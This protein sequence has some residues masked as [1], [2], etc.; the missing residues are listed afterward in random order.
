MLSDRV[1]NL[2]PSPTLALSAKAKELAAEGKP[3]I[4]FTAG[5]PDFSTP[6]SVKAA[7]IEAIKANHT[8]YTAAGGMPALREAV[9]NLLNSRYPVSYSPN[10]VIINCGAKHTL[11]NLFQALC[12][13][14][15]EVIIIS[16]YWV[17]YPAMVALAGGKPVIV[18]AEAQGG[19]IP[20][21][22]KI[23]AA[24]GPRTRAVIL[25]SPSNPTGAVMDANTLQRI[26]EIAA[27]KNVLVISDEIY[28]ELVYPPLKH[29]SVLEVASKLTEKLV[30]IGGV[31]K[32]YSMTGWRIGYAAGPATLISAMNKIQSHSTSNPA[33]ISQ[34]AALSAITG[35][36]SAIDENR[37]NFHQRR[38][39]MVS[40]FNAITGIDCPEPAGAFY[41]WVNVEKLGNSDEIAERWLNEAYVA[42]VPGEGFGCP[43]WLRCSF[44]T[45]M[46]TIKKGI[47]R[48]DAWVADQS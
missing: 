36:Q 39:V 18:A 25:N 40:G 35:D 45:D 33:S 12:N 31:S 11:Y 14:G 47:E 24:I 22:E 7:A 28:N 15:D 37:K 8:R 5:E 43:G 46:E 19:F 42:T 21:P 30:W 9:S 27:G 29:V 41:A 44:A 48:I 38:D 6:E 10:Q 4:N 26:V 23:A 1:Q 16:P 17:S 13:P 3:V 2:E 34:H 20:S 32:T